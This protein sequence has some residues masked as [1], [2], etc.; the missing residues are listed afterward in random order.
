MSTAVMRV[1]DLLLGPSTEATA[2]MPD[3]LWPLF[4]G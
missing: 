1:V 4:Q 3:A 2:R